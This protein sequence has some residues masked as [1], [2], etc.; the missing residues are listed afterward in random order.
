MLRANLYVFI[1]LN[2]RIGEI[3]SEG[4]PFVKAQRPLFP[5]NATHSFHTLWGIEIEW[6]ERMRLQ[7]KII[8]DRRMKFSNRELHI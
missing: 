8:Q 7:E 1:R 4:C 2:G 3:F 5:R 6:N